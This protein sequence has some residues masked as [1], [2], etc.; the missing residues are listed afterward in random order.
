M[1][2]IERRIAQHY[3]HGALQEAIDAG[4]ATWNGLSPSELVE[5][6]TAIDEFHMG[7]RFATKAAAESLRLSPGLRVLDVGCGLGG[8]ARY[9]AMEHDCRV[10]GVD[11]TPEYVEVGASLNRR[12][13][14]G[15]RIALSVASALDTPFPS[16]QFDRCMMLHVG[17]NI[18]DKAALFAE[19]ARV[20][21]PDG[22]LVVY[23]VMRTGSGPIEYPVAWA[24]DETT[25]F[26]AS[27]A[28]YAQAL[29][30]GGFEILEQADKRDF[31]LE[32]FMKMKARLAES[33]PPPL[34]L[35]IL[36]GQDAPRKV[37][38]MIANLRSRA[39][40]PVQILARRS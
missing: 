19:L 24:N 30:G 7:G 22:Y 32:V 31:A 33:G 25:S 13:G 38:N 23:D 12:L 40:A 9:L 10:N 17:M 27:P 26:L 4:L 2:E 5:Q 16:N 8:A 20:L 29:R 6:L 18:S 35:H 1:A 3:T 28:E 37:G 34:G 15:D 21:K 36:M 39:I 14:L 11:L